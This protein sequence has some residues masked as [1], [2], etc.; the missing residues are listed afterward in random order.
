[1]NQTKTVM[2]VIAGTTALLYGEQLSSEHAEAKQ[3]IA[4]KLKQ[5][6]QNTEFANRSTADIR[7]ELEEHEALVGTGTENPRWMRM[8]RVELARRGNKEAR[9]KIFQAIK[10]PVSTVQFNAL[11]DAAQLADREAVYYLA[12]MLSDPTPGGRVTYV[13]RDGTIQRSND[14][15]IPAPRQ[16]AARKLANLIENPPVSPSGG[17]ERYTEEDMAI[18]QKWW[19]EHKAEFKEFWDVPELLDDE[20]KNQETTLEE[21]LPVV[22]EE[23]ISTSVGPYSSNINAIAN[24]ESTP[25][26]LTNKAEQP[27]KTSL[28]EV[29]LW[30][31]VVAFLVIVGGVVV[32]KN[33]P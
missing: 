16:T 32:W 20:E 3:V 12:E 7:S 14:F 22:A 27:E 8:L 18:W 21:V 15:A 9:Q 19:Q 23:P 1:M 29:I 30:I 33:K 24:L 6:P 31:F 2:V 28:S 11:G 5:F 26:I 10:S 17:A 25:P 4:I 13:A